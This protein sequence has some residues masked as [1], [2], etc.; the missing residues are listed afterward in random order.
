MLK[1][2]KLNKKLSALHSILLKEAMYILGKFRIFVLIP[3]KGHMLQVR[4]HHYLY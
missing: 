2:S 1:E 4:N 3:T